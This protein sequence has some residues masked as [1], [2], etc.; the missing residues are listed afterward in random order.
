MWI[1]FKIKI[2]RPERY[3]RLFLVFLL[4]TSNIFE[5]GDFE[6]VDISWEN[7]DRLPEILKWKYL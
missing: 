6:Q 7:L 3:H 2:K 5:Q 4:L 1:I